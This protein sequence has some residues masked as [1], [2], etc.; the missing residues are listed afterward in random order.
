MRIEVLGTA[1]VVGDHGTVSGARLGGR[2]AHIILVALALDPGVVSSERLARLIWGEDTPPTWPAALR[3]VVRGLRQALE[4]V[5]GGAQ[6]V[7]VTEPRGY[8]VAAGVQVDVALAARAVEQ[9]A[10]LVRGGRYRAALDLAGPVSRLT[11]AALL[12]DE[13]GEWLRPHRDQ[14]DALAR[15]GLDL[16]AD[17]AGRL[18]EH[19]AAI[20]A[21]RR[22]LAAD[23]LDEHAHRGLIRALD[24]GGDRAGVVRAYEECRSVLADQLGVD[25]SA[26]TVRTYLAALHDQA[27]SAHARVPVDTSSFVGRDQDAARLRTILAGPGLVTV[28]GLGGVGKSRLAAR[29]AG[30]AEGHSGGRLWVALGSVTEDALVAATVALSLGVS[31]GAEDAAAALAAHLAA[32]GPTLLVLDGAETARDG[33][34]SLVSLLVGA[35]PLLSV[36]VTSRSPLGLDAEAV[37]RLDPLPAPADADAAPAALERNPLVRLLLDRVRDGGGDLDVDQITAPHVVALLRTCGGL[38]LAVE[39][40]A[41]Q[42]AAIPV[43]D[44][45]D[46][47]GPVLHS[48]DGPLRAIARGSYALLNEHEAAVFRRCAVL[49]GSVGLAMVR[50]VVADEQIAPVRVVRILRELTASGLLGVDRSGPRWHYHLDD[51]LRRFAADLLAQHGEEGAAYDRLADAVRALLPEDARQ[52]PAPYQSAVTDALACIRSLF[53]AAVSGRADSSRCLEL[54]FRLHRYWAATNVAEGRY[55]LARLLAASPGSDWFAYATYALGYLDYWSGDT[56]NAL[57]ELETVT[58][59][60]DGVADPYAARALVYLAGLLDDL[61]RGPEAVDC[62]RRSIDA[63]EP[64][65]IDLR[66]AAAMGLGSVLSER[67]EPEAAEH[68]VRA[69]ELCRSG[70]SPEQLA[71][72]LPTA[73]MVCWQVGAVDQARAF[74]RE[75]RPLHAEGK[76]IAR[77]VLLSA[78]AGLALD[79]GDL[80]AAVDL[81]LSADREGAELGV[82]REMPLIRAVLARALLE[83]G[84]TA[85]AGARAA[86]ALDTA[87]GMAFDFPLAVGLETAWLVLR[88]T[89]AAE[90]DLAGLL[91]AAGLVRRRGDRPPP[92]TLARQVDSLRPPPD[93]RPH[94]RADPGPSPVA[95]HGAAVLGHGLGIEVGHAGIAAGAADTP[96]SGAGGLAEAGGIDVRAAGRRALDLLARIGPS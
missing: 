37:H 19:P 12:A 39:L 66:V 92:A 84:D 29:A 82:E 38:P 91:D 44:L 22:R 53:R 77:V 25:P 60:L 8:R 9:A 80:P 57:R 67:G 42:L 59:L 34:A 79:D 56:D 46:Q 65:G 5:G 52:T 83:S 88:H 45:L 40:M 63:A 33:V 75:A 3:G 14:V 4:P 85:G 58:S 28:T 87:L 11:G 55:W 47:L 41:A 7:I 71:V 32:L 72:A 61:D 27:P 69:I 13:D 62:V 18:G 64:F 49:D 48:G 93:H 86:A 94:L 24:R 23:P 74:V 16:V 68:A 30:G 10:D 95:G 17:A 89:G 20:V 50:Q 90:E 36:L 76:R 70:G 96:G 15:Q 2:R 35:C 6:Q 81:G 73:A 26:D 1:A 43:G 54:A 31:P 78:A 51:D 21:A